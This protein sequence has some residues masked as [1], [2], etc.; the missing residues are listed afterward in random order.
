MNDYYFW[1]SEYDYFKREQLKRSTKVLE[2][3]LNITNH[4]EE[5]QKTTYCLQNLGL[6][7]FF[8]RR[9]LTYHY[10]KNFSNRFYCQDSDCTYNRLPM[11]FLF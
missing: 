8:S 5:K 11:Y 10:E 3:L 4:F 1:K 7:I 6:N 2:R 9:H